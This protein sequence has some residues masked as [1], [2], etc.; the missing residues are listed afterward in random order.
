[1]KAISINYSEDF[2]KN[3]IAGKV[4]GVLRDNGFD[5]MRVC[6]NYDVERGINTTTYLFNGS[7]FPKESKLKEML[8]EL[9]VRSFEVYEKN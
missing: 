3:E 4:Y 2:R 9:N 6:E 7:E 1:M 8:D 5:P